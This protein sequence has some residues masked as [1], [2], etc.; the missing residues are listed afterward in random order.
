MSTQI[1]IIERSATRIS[2]ADF[3]RLD[4]TP[5]FWEL[6]EMGV[7][8]AERRGRGEISLRAGPFVGCA[9]VGDIQIRVKEKVAGSLAAL[10]RCVTGASALSASAPTFVSEDVALLGAIAESFVTEVEAYLRSGR[11]RVYYPRESVGASPRGKI[12][13]G[14][15]MRVWATGRRDRCAF[16]LH[17][18]SPE[19]FLNS[20]VG[21]AIAIVGCMARGW[22][23]CE[24][25][26]RR[27][28]TAALLFED[29]DWHRLLKL[30]VDLFDREYSKVA[31][32]FGN[33]AGL[34]GIA[35]LFVRHFGI[36]DGVTDVEVP[37]SW[38]IKLELLF[39]EAFRQA[40]SRAADRHGLRATDW[41]PAM[42][43]V[44]SGGRRWRAEPDVVLWRGAE[45]RAIFDAKYKDIAGEPDHG[46]VYQVLCHAGAWDVGM[47][48]LGHPASATEIRMLGESSEGVQLMVGALDIL[49]LEEACERL[50]EAC[51]LT[52]VQTG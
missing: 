22:P 33:L 6:L 34:A 20:L 17:D 29:T 47:A 52:E 2:A 11:R 19:R 41:R 39:E 4:A 16:A 18:L 45:P 49:H 15:T 32:T 48:A 24:V 5:Q 14:R 50:V 13:V 30:P 27:V 46:D 42:R 3:R 28:R 7:L 26:R 31:S 38:F 44:I 37:R 25:L 43:Y 40:I 10:V 9:N 36:S 51:A 35:R 8:V 1:N 23:E 12:L 21:A